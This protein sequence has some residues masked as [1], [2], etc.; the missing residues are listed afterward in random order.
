[1]I[2]GCSPDTLLMLLIFPVEGIIHQ[3]L[4]PQ[5]LCGL[6][7]GV[8]NLDISMFIFLFDGRHSS[9]GMPIEEKSRKKKE[10]RGVCRKEEMI[11][12]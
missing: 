10:K 9:D 2:L 6:H 1:M 8:L 3:I 11:A 12:L 4:I 5:D 7:F